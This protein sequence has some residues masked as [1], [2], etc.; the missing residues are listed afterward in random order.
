MSGSGCHRSNDPIGGDETMGEPY[1]PAVEWRISTM[2]AQYLAMRQQGRRWSLRGLFSMAD[3]DIADYCGDFTPNRYGA[4]A[5]AEVERFC[6]RHSIWLSADGPHYNSMTPYLHRS[7]VTAERMTTIG[8]FN[9]ILFW[10]ND[11][12]GREKFPHLTHA[13]RFAA[14]EGVLR[15]CETL[16]TGSTTADPTPI[17]EAMAEFR[18]MLV[19]DAADDWLDY[20]IG[21]TIE[22]LTLA[23]R[24][25]NARARGTVPTVAEYI[26]IRG[27]V[28][29]MRPAV[30]L[31]EF[32][33]NEYLSWDRI[34]EAELDAPLTQLRE[35]TVQFAAL[36]N[37]IFSF[38]K[39][40][41]VDR[42]DF[43]LIPV[44]LLNQPRSTLAEAIF[45]AAELVRD[46]FNDLRRTHALLLEKCDDRPGTVAEAVRTHADDLVDGAKATWVWQTTTS[47]YQ[48]ISIFLENTRH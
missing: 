39:E 27:H 3:C 20:F 12:V 29:G 5:C 11:T 15:L 33:R 40:C 47:R 8:I 34:R 38:E 44:C 48:G 22:H 43:N 25:H 42:S 23:I 45:N 24:D 1:R 28:S 36:M 30:A 6:R 37:D 26:D 35:L 7:A 41:I 19:R 16:D 2:R 13:A 10:L 17:T 18:S 32:A 4:L 21:S 14:R 9:A 31:Y 46:R